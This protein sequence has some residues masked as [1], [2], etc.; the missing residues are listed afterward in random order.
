VTSVAVTLLTANRRQRSH[1]ADE[2]RRDLPELEHDEDNL[3]VES[4]M[5]CSL[6]GFE[7]QI[8]E[9]L[10]QTNAEKETTE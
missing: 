10:N 7:K 2:H 1:D 9:F 3:G 5:L 8:V 6:G 4:R